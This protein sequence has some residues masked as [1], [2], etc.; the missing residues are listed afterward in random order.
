M[1]K[2]LLIGF[3]LSSLLG[4]GAI[5][6]MMTDHD[7]RM[8]QRNQGIIGPRGCPMMNDEEHCEGW[9]YEECEEMYEECKEHMHKYCEHN[10]AIGEGKR[11]WH[12]CPMM[13]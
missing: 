4:A 5:G 1:V 9:A 13:H 2:I 11:S 3:V 12:G 6:T 8:G 7:M 10:D